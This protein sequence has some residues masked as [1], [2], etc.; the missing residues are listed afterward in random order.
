VV[1]YSA[2]NLKWSNSTTLKLPNSTNCEAI[3]FRLKGCDLP[4]KWG[5]VIPFTSLRQA[6]GDKGGKYVKPLGYDVFSKTKLK[7][8]GNT[9]HYLG[10][11][12]AE[13]NGTLTGLEGFNYF[14]M[15]IEQGF[16]PWDVKEWKQDFVFAEK[17]ITVF[18]DSAPGFVRNA[19]RSAQPPRDVTYYFRPEYVADYSSQ[20]P[21]FDLKFPDFTLPKGKTTV[22]QVTTERQKQLKNY[23]KK[24]ITYALETDVSKKYAFVSDDWLYALGCPMAYQSSQKDF[25]EWLALTP[26]NRILES[27]TRRITPFKDYGYIMLNWEAV[28][29]RAFGPNREKL[30][31][32]LRWY[33]RQNYHAK[34]SAWNEAPIKIS[35]IQLEGD[36]QASDF[37]G[38]VGFGSDQPLNYD[39]M[40]E[41]YKRRIG[42][43]PTDYA[44]QLD[45]LQVGGYMNYPT[46]FSTIHHY[47][48]EFLLNKKFFPEKTILATIWPTQ[49]LVGTF[50]LGYKTFPDYYC[51]IKPAVFPQVMFNWGVW[52]VA[53][54]DGFDC[55]FDPVYVTDNISQNGFG[56]YRDGKNLIQ[57]NP[58]YPHNS[59]KNVDDLMAGVWAVSQ[60]KD[61][62]DATTAWVW[63]MTADESFFSKKPLMAV[64]LSADG[65][66]MLMLVYDAFNGEAVTEHF[67]PKPPYSRSGG[68]TVKTLG[69]RTSVIRIKL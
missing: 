69:T 2:D 3:F 7:S 64:K 47:L 44:E 26:A 14:P 58:E 17:P 57:S 5:C 46:N 19:A 21:D 48:L 35:R 61:I 50:P 42:F 8:S 4:S 41:K 1:E 31:A 45:V 32:C 29:N 15:T 67:F 18:S 11:A 20:L 34:L 39:A 68:I 59:L 33:N 28:A 65:T 37:A 62:I 24:G 56:C 38:A 55:W 63:N 12:R 25:D 54:G 52:S 9:Q 53:I 6:Q 40:R 16:Q 60:H 22:L 51:F 23:T 27:F 66:E 13:K 10:A 30:T 36:S 43:H 49:E